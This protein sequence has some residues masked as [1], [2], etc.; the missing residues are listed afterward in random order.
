MSLKKLSRDNLIVDGKSRGWGCVVFCFRCL[1]I[2]VIE[3]KNR[4]LYQYGVG[5]GG[6]MPI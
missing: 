2:R 1:I 3:L 4:A 6:G 5:G